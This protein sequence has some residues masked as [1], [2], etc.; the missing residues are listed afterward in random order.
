MSH[1][2]DHAEHNGANAVALAPSRTGLATPDRLAS[3]IIASCR[4]AIMSIT[5]D[6]LIVTWNAAAERLTGY[7]A[8]EMIGKSWQTLSHREDTAQLSE[9]VRRFERDASTFRVEA[10][11]V[12]KDGLVV[13]ILVSISAILDGAATVIGLSG[14]LRDITEDKQA[15]EKLRQSE[16]RFKTVF[17]HSTDAISVASLTDGKYLEVN[18]EFVRMVGL[19][20]EQIIGKDPLELKLLTAEELSTLGTALLGSGTVRN[21]EVRLTRSDG[22]TSVSL[23]SAVIVQVGAEQCSLGIS[24]DITDLKRAEDHLLDIERQLSEVLANAP[25][26]MLAIDLKRRITVARGR[27]VNAAGYTDTLLGKSITDVFLPHNQILQHMDRALKGETFMAIDSIID[28]LMSFEVWYSPV[29]DSEHRVAGAIAIGTDITA[30]MKAE[31]EL[32]R[33]EEYYRSLVENSSDVTVVSN[34]EGVII[35]AAGQG[36]KDFGYD[37]S[38]FVGHQTLDFIHPDKHREQIGRI[39]QSF[40]KADVV[41]RGEAPIRCKDGSWIDCEFVG[42]A[43]VGPD[44][45]PLLVSTVRNISARKSAELELARSR[46]KALAASR[47]KSEFLSSMSHEI[48]TPMNAIL[49]MADLMWETDLNPEQRRYLDTVINNGN[50]LLELINSILDLAKVESGRLSLETVEFDLRELIDKIADILAVRADG[51]HVELAVIIDQDVP[52]ALIGDPLRLRQV[53][54]NLIGNAIKFTQQGSV[55][56]RVKR[57]PE[58]VT[59]LLFSVA[60]T[61]IGIPADKIGTLFTPFSQADSSVTRKYGGTGLGLAIVDRLVQLMGGRVG[62]TSEPGRGSTFSFSCEFQ[63]QPPGAENIA[64]PVPLIDLHQVKVLVVDDNETNRIILRE[65]VAPR[66]AIVIEAASGKEGIDKFESARQAGQPFRL[67]IADQLMPGMDGLEMVSRIR[68]LSPAKQLTIMMLT[69]TDLPETLAKVRALGIGC[70]IVKPIKRSELYAA[71]ARTMKEAVG[72]NPEA[73]ASQVRPVRDPGTILERPLKILMADDSPDN[74]LLI[75]SYLRKTPYRLDEA[76]DGKVATEMTFAGD[77]DLILMDIQ[78]PEMDG[79]TAVRNI[80]AWE[81]R[82]AR[83]RI[84][85]IALTASALDEAVRHTKEVGFDLHVSKPVKRSTLLNAIVQAVSKPVTDRYRSPADAA[86]I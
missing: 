28:G 65:M 84:P 24:K 75:R 18:D 45:K 47:S 33:S 57:A 35:F 61:G 82:T 77:Y 78:M 70:Y 38:E 53:L 60:D 59:K 42:R 54:T 68:A 86:N 17:A 52:T 1:S 46:D 23:V 26:A 40:A 41:G 32:R 49:G 71:I 16:E 80:R 55:V 22:T 4:E 14:I 31:D 8:R 58:A 27:A 19:P 56:V 74:R 7:T 3:A 21:R 36:S 34:Q 2:N 13:Q 81:N 25:V 63:L 15:A 79:Y 20:R 37:A 29:S 66:G 67:L 73:V 50:A 5:M 11:L 72:G 39:T 48:R 83:A 10:R 64:A 85:I 43:T 12:R 6:G 51:K 76:N 9:A 44:G 69:S 62:L 30:R